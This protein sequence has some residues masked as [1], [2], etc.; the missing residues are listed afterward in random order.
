MTSSEIRAVLVGD[1]AIW[2]LAGFNFEPQYADRIFD[3]VTKKAASLVIDLRGNGG[4]MVKTLEQIAGRLFDKD[5]KLADLNGRRS[6][7]AVTATR[8]R[9]PRSSRACCSSKAVVSWSGTAPP[10]R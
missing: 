1:V 3:S 9:P 8:R 7:K 4:G 5:V 10:D 6:M 2:K